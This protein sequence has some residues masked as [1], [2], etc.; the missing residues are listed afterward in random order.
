MDKEI[1][2]EVRRII[3]IVAVVVLLI[4]YSGNIL[5]AIGGIV[6]VLNPFFAGVVIAFVLNI[7]MTSIEEKCLANWNGNMKKKLRRGISMLTSIFIVCA[8]F[9][10]ISFS[11]V[12]Q[13][14]DT[15]RDIGTRVPE[16][17]NQ[18]VNYV[19]QI[20]KDYPQINEIV[21]EI[22]SKQQDWSRLL[23]SIGSF[24]Q[25]GTVGNIVT[26]TVNVASSIAVF[27]F[28]AI[29]AI[30]FAIY[31]LVNKEK[32]LRNI[33]MVFQTYLPKKWFQYSYHA[34]EVLINTFR[35]FIA[36]QCVEAVI[37][38]LI[39][40]LF[41]MIFRIP[42]VLLISVL[43]AF[44]ALIPVAGAFIGCFI[45]AFLILMVSPIKMIE[46]LI[47]FI[48]IQQFENKLIYPRI[49]GSSVGLPAIWVFVAVTVGGSLCG[50]FGMLVFIPLASTM[51]E[52]LRE[53]IIKRNRKPTAADKLK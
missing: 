44:T 1:I 15:C 4:V 27:I 52:L 48:I 40:A 12:P 51:Y 31:I 20:T 36:G 38:G 23:G 22:G 43:I 8:V 28:R 42:Y 35:K 32:L 7:P 49:V 24:M 30:C 29:I 21:N 34:M 13:L 39:F 25:S 9:F 45:G 6:E 46:F 50:V 14:A 10:L 26:S 5:D 19:N 16:F 17:Y 41:M 37:L 2:K 33:K 11:I 47:L 53:D 18:I 3:A